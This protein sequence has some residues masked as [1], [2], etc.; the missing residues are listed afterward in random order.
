MELT[1]VGIR[2][3]EKSLKN[4]CEENHGKYLH[5]WDFAKDEL[6]GQQNVQFIFQVFPG[7]FQGFSG[8]F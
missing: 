6:G 2:I 1:F 3:L 8:I 7:V 5:V 4:T